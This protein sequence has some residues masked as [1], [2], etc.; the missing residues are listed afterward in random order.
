MGL[1]HAA[2]GKKYAII[3]ELLDV[4][5]PVY[6]PEGRVSLICRT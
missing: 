5:G 4:I 3:K 6:S 1:T 2:F